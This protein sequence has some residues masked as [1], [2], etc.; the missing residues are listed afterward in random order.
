MQIM[1]NL[2][3]AV[4]TTREHLVLYYSLLFTVLSLK[5]GS[6]TDYPQLL[7]NQN[8]KLTLSDKQAKTRR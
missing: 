3:A 1:A 6:L 7:V 5:G 8:S 4:E 2:K